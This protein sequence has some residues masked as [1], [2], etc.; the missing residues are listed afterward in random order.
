M[1]AAEWRLFLTAVRAE[2]W[3]ALGDAVAAAD[4]YDRLLPYAGRLAIS[5]PVAFHGSVELSLGRLART[6]GRTGDAREHLRRARDVHE[7]LGLRAWVAV[8]DA[9]GRTRMEARWSSTAAVSS[10]AA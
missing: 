2:V 10:A 9:S 1:T 3:S 5:V 8:T 4:P 6:L 7:R